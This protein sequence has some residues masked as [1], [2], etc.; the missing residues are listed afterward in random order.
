[1]V[2]S[3]HLQVSMPHV[4]KLADLPVLL[5]PPIFPLTSLG[6]IQGGLALSAI[7]EL[8]IRRCY[9]AT[10]VAALGHDCCWSGVRVLECC[11][12]LLFIMHD[13]EMR[14]TRPLS[15][16]GLESINSKSREASAGECDK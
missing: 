6:T 14:R 16:A 3:P 11:D 9:D 1:M 4:E 7:L 15:T 5:L 10:D 13:D 8:D 12:L 2:E